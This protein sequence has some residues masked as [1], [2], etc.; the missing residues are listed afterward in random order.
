[1]LTPSEKSVLI[2]GSSTGIGRDAALRRDRRGGRGCAGVRTQA[3]ADSLRAAAGDRLTPVIID[4]AKADSI[5]AC[6]AGL[7]ADLGGAGLGAVVNNAGVGVGGPMEFVP[8]DDL[9]WVFE[10]NVFG[11]VAVTQAV[12]PLIRRAE[13][14][15]VVNVGSIAGKLNTPLMTPYCASKHPVEA[16][17]DGLRA[18]LG[19]WKMWACVVE[20]G[21]IETPIW[22]KADDALDGVSDKLDATGIALYGGL[23]DAF[24]RRLRANRKRATPVSAVSD[25]IEHALCS[26]NPRTRYPVGND[27]KMGALMRRI[28]PDAAMDWLVKQI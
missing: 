19:A 14:G 10:V 15:R 26:P 1:M 6:V 9:R 3:D 25:A 21:V 20:P 2:T 28:L 23:V 7:E 18:E 27:A 5:A 22:D 12:L 13:G 17:T 4:V 11:L 8:M 16:I 24:A